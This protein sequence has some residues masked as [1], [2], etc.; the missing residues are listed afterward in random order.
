MVSQAATIRVASQFNDSDIVDFRAEA[1]TWLNGERPFH[2]PLEFPEVFK[3]GA[4]TRLF[5]TLLSWVAKR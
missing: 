1:R 2:W 4:S 3:E 5:V